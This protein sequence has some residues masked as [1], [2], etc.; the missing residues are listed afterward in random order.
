MTRAQIATFKA[1]HASQNP[2]SPPVLAL[3]D[4]EAVEL[5][6]DPEV[7]EQLE[8]VLRVSEGVDALAAV[9]PMPTEPDAIET[10]ALAKHQASKIL[11]DGLAGAVIDGVTLIRKRAS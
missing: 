4:A 8:H 5:V 9:P 11:W 1:F 7:V 6:Q 3:S 2:T 10:W